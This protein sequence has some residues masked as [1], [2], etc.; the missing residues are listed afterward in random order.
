MQRW[1]SGTS[2]GSQ[3]SATNIRGRVLARAVERAN[4]ERAV[5][6]L[7]PL[8]GGLTPH[9]LRRAFASLL[10]AIGETPPYVMA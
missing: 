9:S 6:G 5:T 1:C 8:V 4:A 7:E 10:F 3:H 2:T